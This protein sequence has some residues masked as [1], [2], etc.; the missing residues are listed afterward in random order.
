MKKKSITVRDI[1]ENLNISITTVSFVLNG[2]GKEKHISEELTKKVLDYAFKVNYRP[3]QLAQSLRTGKS[4][5]LVFMVEDISNYFFSQMARII[6]ETAYNKGYRVVFCSTENKEARAA[7]LIDLFKSKQVDG[8]IIAP[9][10]GIKNK[11]IELM[12]ENIPVIL[13]DNNFSDLDCN[14]LVIDN[15]K[16]A[17]SATNHLIING[18][19]NIAFVTIDSDQ[20]QIQRRLS[21]YENA[22]AENN[23]KSYVLKI[24]CKKAG[25]MNPNNIIKRFIEDNKELDAIF[26]GANLLTQSGLEVLKENK[27]ELIHSLGIVIFDDNELFKAYS[28]TITA[29]K[30]PLKTM[31]NKL[32]EIMLRLL[33][34]KEIKET[35]EKIELNAE[36]IIRESS[37]RNI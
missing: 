3:N 29:V 2:K 8:F 15:H 7:E 28:P 19:K 23:L 4:K 32:M 34:Q 12:E 20:M 24:S 10:T 22:I 11:I 30:Q 26:F 9:F 33:D 36:L 14:S 17:F 13:L 31:G 35:F 21:G 27:P 6:E 18:F 5:I 25:K 37:V 1:A 16:A